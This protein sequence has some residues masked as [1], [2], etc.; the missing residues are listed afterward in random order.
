V[1]LGDD[2]FFVSKG[3]SMGG[4]AVFSITRGDDGEWIAKKL[5]HN[6]RV[7]MTKENN[8][9]IKD[10]YIYGPADGTLQCADLE[11]GR[12]QWEGGQRVMQVLRVGDVLLVVCETGK[13]TLVAFDPENYRELTSFQ[14]LEGQ[15]WNNPALAGKYLLVRN[16]QEA[17]CYELPLAEGTGEEVKR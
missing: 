7:L 15:T 3:Y 4:G 12:K 17:A 9:V 14:A 6:R 2:R 1:P 16:G 5:W 11:K 8:V 13:I 10:G